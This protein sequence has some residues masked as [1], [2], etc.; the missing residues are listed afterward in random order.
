MNPPS[1]ERGFARGLL[2]VLGPALLLGLVTAL[3][4][5]AVGLQQQIME[6]LVLA[7]S[8]G[9]ATA[10]LAVMLVYRQIIERRAAGNALQNIQARAGGLLESAMDAIIVID[11]A[12]RILQY[13]AAAEKV[14][15]WPRDAM[16]GQPL[17]KLIPER[18]RG[19]HKGHVGRFGNTGVT[20]RRMGD[21]TVV[22]GLRA[23]GEEFPIEASI[24]QH[25]EDG[26]TLFTVI[27][28][29]ISERVRVEEQQ[30][31]GEA[32][33]RGILDSA[34]DAVITVDERQHIVLFNGAAEKVF[35][36]PRDEAIGAPLSWLIPERFRAEHGEHMKH[37]GDTG[38]T[39]RRMGGARRITGLRR[40]G[41]EFPI[42][43]SISQV[44]EGGARFYTVILR[45]VTERVRAEEA[46]ARS[47]EE[48]NEQ[49]AASHT[50]L[51]QE[52]SR[53]ARELHDE[54][55]Q[56]LTALKLDVAW[57]D[58][59]ADAETKEKLAKMR[60]ILDNTVAA[61]RRIAADLRPLMLDDLGFLP[62]AE[63]LVHSFRERNRIECRLMIEQED[64]TLDEPY[65]TAVFRILQESLT[66]IAKHAQAGRVEVS[67]DQFGGEVRLTVLDDGKG[68]APADPRKPHSYGLLGLRERVHLVGGEVKIDS[69]PGR[70]TRVAV[71][72]PTD[73]IA[74]S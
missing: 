18:Y 70:G 10:L 62:A 44:V 65:A 6:M 74:A 37:F 13:N 47:R 11:E 21:R 63:W 8:V 58:E 31:R 26:V 67:L 32:R 27:L 34:M 39:S 51:E 41:E 55:A 57:L 24:S 1:R 28:R 43:A 68:F 66:N 5:L 14:F 40:N 73:R 64:I 38:T 15:L 30:S 29:D 36:C 2:I 17:D 25:R 7:A 56:A 3:G 54:L 50:M 12:Q 33:L 71:R 16:L 69:T 52:K 35:G 60:G 46:L 53:V 59:R 48:L 45:D 9:A 22:T 72:I 4:A 19:A 23:N 20:S 42:E 49:A 61:T